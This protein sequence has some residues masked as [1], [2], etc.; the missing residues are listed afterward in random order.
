[1]DVLQRN[2][3]D[4]FK[5][6]ARIATTTGA[7]TGLFVPEQNRLYVA[8]PHRGMQFAEVRVYETRN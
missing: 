8:V 2:A 6:V 4:A 3:G 7:R 5:R 1:V